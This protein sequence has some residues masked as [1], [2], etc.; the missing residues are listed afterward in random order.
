MAANSSRKSPGPSVACITLPASARQ[1]ASAAISSHAA[2]RLGT[3]RPSQ[4]T[5]V[6][7]LE[8]AKPI[9]PARSASAT[10]ARIA[11]TSSAVASRSIASSPIT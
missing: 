6:G 3:G 5:C 11:A 8:V 9:A 2:T 4:P 10:S 7:D 1:P